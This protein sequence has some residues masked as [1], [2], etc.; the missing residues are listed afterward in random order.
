M[1]NVMGYELREGERIRLGFISPEECPVTEIYVIRPMNLLRVVDREG[2]LV[3]DLLK[4]R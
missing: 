2:N 3:K 1:G 4:K